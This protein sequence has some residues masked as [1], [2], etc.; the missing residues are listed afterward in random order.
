M[1]THA[2]DFLCHNLLYYSVRVE[3]CYYHGAS[4]F[5]DCRAL[6]KSSISSHVSSEK[7][8][9]VKANQEDA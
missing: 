4:L 2:H 9:S 8:D 3:I 5:P 7:V 6:E 1:A